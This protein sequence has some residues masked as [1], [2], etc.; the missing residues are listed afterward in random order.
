MLSDE[1][2]HYDA[3]DPEAQRFARMLFFSLWPN[4]GGFATYADGLSP[5]ER[6]TLLEPR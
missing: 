2:P 1:A 6:S 4:G 3:L 5:C